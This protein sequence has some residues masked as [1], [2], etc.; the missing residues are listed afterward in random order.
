MKLAKL[1]WLLLAS[2][3]SGA[4]V[5]TACTTYPSRGYYGYRD[6]YGYRDNYYPYRYRSAYNSTYYYP[7]RSTRYYPY[8]SNYYPYRDG[9]SYYR[10]DLR[11]DNRL[12]VYV[13]VG[14]PDH[15]Y[16]DDR[17]Y[18]YR[19]NRWYSSTNLDGDWRYRSYRNVPRGLVREYGRGRTS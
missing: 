8:T 17:Y 15:F 12:G 14:M 18:L 13:V 5:T 3:I 10:P 1:R 6:S 11:Y 16:Y 9:Y 4:L 7:Y 2:L 19:D